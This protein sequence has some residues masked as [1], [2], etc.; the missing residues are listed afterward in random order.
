MNILELSQEMPDPTQS[1]PQPSL[2]VSQELWNDA[3]YF[4]NPE[5]MLTPASKPPVQPKPS[6]FLSMSE[7]ELNNLQYNKAKNTHRRIE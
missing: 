7:T 2:Q 5:P 6:H 3:V 4:I 1:L